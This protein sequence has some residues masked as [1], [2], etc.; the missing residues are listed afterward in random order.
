[1]LLLR[2]RQPRDLFANLDQLLR[3]KSGNFLARLGQPGR[4]PFGLTFL[5][6]L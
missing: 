2:R 4:M 3:C 6:R 5:A 1:M